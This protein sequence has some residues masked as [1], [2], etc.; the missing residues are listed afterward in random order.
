MA[1]TAPTVEP[2][3]TIQP[4][5]AKGELAPALY[6]RVDTAAYQVGLRKA[7]NAVI[8][9]SG[10]VSNRPGLLFIGECNKHDFDPRLIEFQYKTT[11]QYVLEFGDFYMR[12]IRDDAHVVEVAKNIA[13]SVQSDPVTVVTSGN[14]GWTTGDEVYITGI[15]GMT[16]LNGNRYKITVVNV[17]TFSLQYQTS[18]ANVN[19]AAFVAYASGGTVARVYT[20]TTP[21]AKADLEELKAVQDANTM[22]LTHPSYS[23]R[24]LTRTGHAAWTLTEPTFAP[25]IASPTGVT[26]SPATPAA[27]LVRYKVTATDAETSEESLSALDSVAKTITG[28]TAANPCHIT[29]V[30]H[31][32]PDGAEIQI[33]GVV[34]MTQLNGRRFIVSGGTTDH[35]DLL[36]EDSTSYTAYA[37]GGTIHRT[38]TAISNGNVTADNT[39][40]WTAASGAA[41]YTVYKEKNG[42]YG[43]IGDTQATTFL[44]SNIAPSLTISPPEARNPFL[45]ADNYPAV[46]SYYEQRRVMGGSNN[47]PATSYYSQ[48]AN[49]SNMSVSTPT[50]ADDAITARLVS[51]KVSAIRHYVPGN[52]LL[53]FTNDSE[54]RVNSGPDTAFAATT[55]RQK[56]Q[57]EWGC[58]HLRPIKAGNTVLFVDASNAIVRTFGY[59]LQLDGYSGNNIG[60]LASHLLR[61]NLLVDWTYAPAPETRIHMARD[62]GKALTMTFDQEQSVVAWTTW[63]TKGKFTRCATLR[64][65]ASST[66]DGVYF[67][68]KRIINGTTVRYIEKQ[69][70]RRFTDVQD[71]YFV[72]CGLSYD[73]PIAI[74]GATAANPVVITAPA[75]GLSNGDEVDISDI[76]WTSTIDAD[77]NETQPDQLNRRRYTVANKTT[78]TFE[79]S[80][81]DGTAFDA[82]VEDGNVRKA[83]TTISGFSHLAG[84]EIVLLANG[85]VITGT[86]VSSTGTITLARKASRVH[87][88]LSYISDFETLDITAATADQIQ[89]RTKKIPKATFRFERSRG[90]LYGTDIDSLTEMKQRE[91][92][93]MSDPTQLLTG[94]KEC[95]FNSGW[96][97]HGRIFMRQ[98]NP[99]PL[100]VLAVIPS[101]AVGG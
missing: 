31:G 5:F 66:E 80:G 45:F 48:T 11:D 1:A 14:H 63:D 19:G 35:F 24:E 86:T 46:A 83:V 9:P 34:G 27:E 18:G 72:D 3:R 53:I 61:D 58:S 6:G 55:I 79:L 87:G 92:E 73:N 65:D 98:V 41:R 93:D 78:N 91:N 30:A 84:E 64:Q 37:S 17:T 33:D 40:A 36:N 38:Y 97:T 95:T 50:Q 13:S 26:V 88:G 81:A 43:F 22:T 90:F 29:A 70:S 75:H 51:R 94:D 62:D 71:C 7:R 59:T 56:Q 101:F 68:V 69:A 67:V 15:V 28:A 2:Q 16:E 100:T 49:Q 57:T 74:T 8:H 39:I 52:D 23:P 4:S 89:G 99:L 32:I 20:L 82:Y 44:D 96:D 42:L 47:N 85:S 25:H 60:I 77:G 21:Y 10:G 54:W 76:I 12:V